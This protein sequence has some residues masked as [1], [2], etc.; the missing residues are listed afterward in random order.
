M[1]ETDPWP[2]AL[3]EVMEKEMAEAQKKEE[4]EKKKRQAA[5]ETPMVLSGRMTTPARWTPRRVGL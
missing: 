5:L 2:I 4:E 3:Q 1:L